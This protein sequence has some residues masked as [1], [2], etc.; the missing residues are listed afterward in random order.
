MRPL[1]AVPVAL[2]SACAAAP[3]TPG[4]STTMLPALAVMKRASDVRFTN[5]GPEAVVTVPPCGLAAPV[6]AGETVR[7]WLEGEAYRCALVAK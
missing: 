4:I 5:D 7:V 2:L 1:W 3:E 6:R